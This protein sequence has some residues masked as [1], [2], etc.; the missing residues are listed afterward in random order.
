[1]FKCRRSKI[2]REN[3]TDNVISAYLLTDRVHIPKWQAPV[4]ALAASRTK[5]LLAADCIGKLT[6][7]SEV[8][9][10]TIMCL[11]GHSG[12]QH[13]ET[14]DRLGMEGV[15]TRPIGLEPFLPLSSGRFKSKTRNWIEKKKYTYG[16]SV[17]GME[18]ANYVWRDQPI[19]IG[20]C[21]VQSYIQCVS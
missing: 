19:P 10:V 16:E 2:I 15:R 9:Q 6:A 8:N 5:S 3:Q 4:A 12:N 21:S 18:P 17:K 7:L 20:V 1:M 11:L 14:A 13:N